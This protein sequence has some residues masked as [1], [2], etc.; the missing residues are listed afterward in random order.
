MDLNNRLELLHSNGMI[1][2]DVFNAV[3]KVIDRMGSR[4]NILLTEN[5]GARLVTHLAMA[6]MR[7]YK[8][9]PVASMDSDIYEEFLLCD[10]FAK[11]S[12]IAEDLI[13]WAALDVPSSEKEYLNTNLCLIIDED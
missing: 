6:L 12:M 2:K 5:N 10:S 7:I 4:W 3:K 11:A 8:G 9:E 13:D 1:S